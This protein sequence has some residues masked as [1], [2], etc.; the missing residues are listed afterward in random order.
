MSFHRLI[1]QHLILLRYCK[2][3]FLFNF[4]FVS[5]TRKLSILTMLSTLLLNLFINSGSYRFY[6][7]SICMLTSSMTN[8]RVFFPSIL[9]LFFSCFIALVRNTSTMK[10][11]SD[12]SGKPCFT[13][14]LRV[15]G[16]GGFYNLSSSMMFAVDF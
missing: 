11:K 8:D 6:G 12:G 13:S 10:N 15:E 7:I 1:P 16:R 9:I 5:G 14:S 3:Y 2:C 4:L